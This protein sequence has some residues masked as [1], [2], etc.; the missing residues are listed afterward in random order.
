MAERQQRELWAG[1]TWGS[2][3]DV[4][5]PVGL[6]VVAILSRRPARRIAR[7]PS[8]RPAAG[9]TKNGRR[10]WLTVPL[11]ASPGFKTSYMGHSQVIL[12]RPGFEPG[13]AI[14]GQRN[15]GASHWPAAFVFQRLPTATATDLSLHASSQCFAPPHCVSRP[16]LAKRDLSRITASPFADLP[17]MPSSQPRDSHLADGLEA[18]PSSHST[19]SLAAS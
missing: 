2:H 11:W 9:H 1:R 16:T 13:L 10:P 4:W 18:Q 15:R 14:H 7:Q 17:D 6:Q 12:N 3:C 5:A 19:C 8:P